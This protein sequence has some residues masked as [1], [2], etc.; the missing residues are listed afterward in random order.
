MR[1]SCRCA[2]PI[3]FPSTTRTGMRGATCCSRP[4]T[5][6]RPRPCS[7]RRFRSG[8]G[9]CASSSCRS[10]SASRRRARSRSSSARCA[11]S[12]RSSPSPSANARCWAGRRPGSTP[13]SCTATRRFARFE[14]TFPLL[15][16]LGPPVHYTGFVL[17]PGER[18][19]IGEGGE[20]KEVVVSAGGGAVGIEHLALALAAQPK[21]RFGHLTW[22]V[23]AGPNIPDEGMQR[24][25]RAAGPMAVVERA[26][27]DFPALLR[28]AFVSVS[29]GGYNTVMDVVVSG[30]RPV[31][32][33]FTGNGETEQRA[34][35]VR[36][37]EFD[38]AIVV[39]DRTNT[40]D[41]LAAAVDAAGTRD[42]WG[43]WTFDSEGAARSAAIVTDLVADRARMSGAQ[44]DPSPRER[45]AVVSPRSSTSGAT[46]AAKPT[47]GGATTMRAA[48]RPRSSG[49]SLSRRRRRFRSRSPSF[50]RTSRGA[51][52]TPW[53][54]PTW[55]RR[56]SM[57]TRIATMRLRERATGSSART[58][59]ST[60][61]PASSQP[62]ARALEQAFG[63]R[64][65]PV[66]VPP[67]NRIDE[68]VIE[69]LPGAGFSGLSTF[70][71]EAAM[72]SGAGSCA[73]QHACRP[74]RVAARSSL[75]RRR[76]RGRPP[77]GSSC[78]ASRGHR[79]PGGAHRAPHA[80]S[81]FRRQPRG[82]F[83]A[84]L[85][86]RTQAHGAAA[87]VDAA[88]A[89]AGVTSPRSA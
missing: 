70:G 25:L 89:F 28:Q 73:V 51:S 43:R 72:A 14:E 38:L 88:T 40:P 77:G 76:G 12:C 83:S 19:A 37:D 9:R 39:D 29:Q 31:V 52:P 22:R 5:P 56:S 7:S 87:W 46:P 27:V 15:H 30:A 58:G 50:R 68:A 79:R 48:T 64:F 62:V 17:A 65:A 1:A 67:W 11:T 20:R 44:R 81:G 21:S 85:F 82:R 49:F 55:P 45:L 78:R 3:T 63:R 74:D 10:S 26:R 66:L 18:L 8:G 71:P 54:R 41:V 23:L 61:S 80:S 16:E 60:S 13:F 57:G 59:R 53:R 34:R 69:R 24:L 47:S 42:R 6:S 32:V 36:L 84:E 4:T 33:P 86:A 75:H 35:G 2:T